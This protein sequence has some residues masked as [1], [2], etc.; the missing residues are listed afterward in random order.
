MIHT[1]VIDGAVSSRPNVFDISPGIGIEHTP[2]IAMPFRAYRQSQPDGLSGYGIC[3][4]SA[5]DD[6]YDMEKM[7]AD[8]ARGVDE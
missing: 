5:E 6:L 3:S 7:T 2:G 4:I 1:K 8:I